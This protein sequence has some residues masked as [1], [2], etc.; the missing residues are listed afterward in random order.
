MGESKLC[1]DRRMTCNL[2]PSHV[3]V[4]VVIRGFET[5][6]NRSNGTLDVANRSQNPRNRS[7]WT[8][9]PRLRDREAPGSNPGPPTKN[10]IQNRRFA[11]SAHPSV[12]HGRSQI[13]QEVA[14]AAPAQVDCGPSIELARGYRTADMS[15]RARPR[16]REAPGFENQRPC[17]R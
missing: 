4:H 1:F 17:P 6:R 16:D 15:V 3:V 10:R 12:S 11:N 2:G 7:R 13:F 9:P 14:A 5:A 8:R